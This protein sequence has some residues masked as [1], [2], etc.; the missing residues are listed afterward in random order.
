MPSLTEAVAATRREALVGATD[1]CVEPAGLD[2]ARVGGSKYPD[3]SRVLAARP[4]LVLA[5]V[6]E[7]RLEDVEALRVAGIPVWVTYPR[8]LDAALESLGRLMTA[9]GSPDPGWLADAR[10]SW[11]APF[12]GVRRTAIVPVWRRPWVV[13]GSDTFA[14]DVL[15]RLG[16]DNAYGSASER[17]PRPPLAELRAVDADLVVLPDEPYLF[18]ADDGP[19]AF[20]GRPYALVSGRLLTWYGPSLAVARPRLAA[21][22]G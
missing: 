11:A 13:V 9:I 12:D 3:L 19:E 8:T 20:P 14:G 21:A 15:A 5:N 18:T 7:N 4:D 22:L 17:Y 10:E 2:V 1:F 16:I 6:E